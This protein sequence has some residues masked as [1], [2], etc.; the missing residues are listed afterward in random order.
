ME[1]QIDTIQTKDGFKYKID[2][3]LFVKYS[4]FYKTMVE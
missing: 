4:G 2:H 1:G 3:Q